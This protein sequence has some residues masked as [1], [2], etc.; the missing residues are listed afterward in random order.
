[1]G[2]QQFEID[3]PSG[4]WGWVVASGTGWAEPGHWKL[5]T[6]RVVILI[7]GIKFAEGSFTI[8]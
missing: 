8:E 5:G 3:A 6:Y 1:M 4:Q 2:T 7:D